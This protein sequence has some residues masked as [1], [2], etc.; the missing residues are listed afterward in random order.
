MLIF[1]V[2][3]LADGNSVRVCTKREIAEKLPTMKPEDILSMPEAQL[4]YFEEARPMT[5]RVEAKVRLACNAAGEDIPPHFS[6]LQ[7]CPDSFRQ[8]GQPK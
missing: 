4:F 3:D 7:D 1:T 8:F 6:G 5:C 2:Y